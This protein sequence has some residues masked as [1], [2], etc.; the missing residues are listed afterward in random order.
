MGRPACQSKGAQADGPFTN[1]PL[2]SVKAEASPTIQL[3]AM[4]YQRQF[5]QLRGETPFSPSSRF[6]AASL[7]MAVLVSRVALPI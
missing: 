2:A 7:A 3:L 1:R 5:K 4:T 6:S